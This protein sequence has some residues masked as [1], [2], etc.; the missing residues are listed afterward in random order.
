MGKC[1]VNDKKHYNVFTE[2]D[3]RTKL[4]FQK[5]NKVKLQN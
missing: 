4:L 1:Q 3:D 5:K 2:V